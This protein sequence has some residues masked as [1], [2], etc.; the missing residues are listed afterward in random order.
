MKCCQ[1]LAVCVKAY[2][3]TP[4]CRLSGTTVCHLDGRGDLRKKVELGNM[5]LC[6]FGGSRGEGVIVEIFLTG[7]GRGGSQRCQNSRTQRKGVI[8]CEWPFGEATNDEMVQSDL[9]ND[10]NGSKNYETLRLFQ[11]PNL[12]LVNHKF[13]AVHSGWKGKIRERVLLVICPIKGV[14]WKVVECFSEWETCSGLRQ[15]RDAD[16]YG[17]NMQLTVEQ[18][19]GQIRVLIEWWAP[20]ELKIPIEIGDEEVR[21][22]GLL[23]MN[24]NATV[25]LMYA[26]RQRILIA[27]RHE[28]FAQFI[29]RKLR[30]IYGYLISDSF[31]DYS[32]ITKA[33]Y[34]VDFNIDE[35]EEM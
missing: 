22:E 6:K 4:C 18:V 14:N 12:F 26:R 17:R 16:P 25:A 7:S 31:K 3:M 5:R 9:E 35:Q 2:H 15:K 10:E 1:L 32:K 8:I 20:Q 19:L 30:K 11:N 29:E 33:G 24:R 28:L 27:V 21:E 34:E 13:C 23:R